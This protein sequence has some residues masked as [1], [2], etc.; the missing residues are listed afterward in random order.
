MT[1]PE[2]PAE[3]SLLDVAGVGARR[4]GRRLARGHSY[5]GTLLVLIGAFGFGVAAPD[6]P[7]ATALEVTLVGLAVLATARA[8]MLRLKAVR[9]VSIATAVGVVAALGGSTIQAVGVVAVA[10]MLL[11]L[12]MP[13]AVLAGLTRTKSRV[14]LETVAAALSLYIVLGF[15]F[16]YLFQAVDAFTSASFFAQ[17]DD[18]GRSDLLY[19]SF[20]TLTTTGYGD[21]SA[22]TNLG[23]SFAVLES[24]LGQLYLVSAVAL[25]VGNLGHERRRPFAGTSDPP[26]G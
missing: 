21:L 20:V 2:Q 3:P 5:T 26:D 11:C 9:V 13:L 24:V 18:P 15:F 7:W 6:E 17:T 10:G 23:R 22:A 1:A 4:L 12:L 25:V 19:F 8:G 14:D 16:S